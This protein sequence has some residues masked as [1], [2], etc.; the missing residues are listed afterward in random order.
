MLENIQVDGKSVEAKITE[1]SKAIKAAEGKAK[2]A[3]KK[4]DR[5]QRDAREKDKALRDALHR[6][7]RLRELAFFEKG[8]PKDIALL[9]QE[10]LAKQKE[11]ENED[12]KAKEK[13]LQ[14][15]IHNLAGRLQE[16]C[17]HPWVIYREGYRGSQYKDYDDSYPEK[18][19]CPICGL[20]QQGDK[21]SLENSGQ[22]LVKRSWLGD[23]GISQKECTNLPLDE[24]QKMFIQAIGFNLEPIPIEQPTEK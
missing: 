20:S 14:E 15:E 18:R 12:S 6:L 2:T 3:N 22:R 24:L 17:R 5:A 16:N 9:R 23:W 11:L 1:A 13:K 4:L 10:L 21:G 7:E 8:I 19:F